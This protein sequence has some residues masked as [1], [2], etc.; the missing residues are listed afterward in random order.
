MSH[1]PLNGGR[2]IVLISLIK[3]VDL[4]IDAILLIQSLLVFVAL[5][6]AVFNRLLSLLW[7]NHNENGTNILY[8]QQCFADCS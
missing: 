5:S 8:L 2:S 6:M 1:L 3:K 4:C 7:N